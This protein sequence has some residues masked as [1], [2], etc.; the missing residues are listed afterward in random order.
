MYNCGF[1]ASY[2]ARIRFVVVSL[3]FFSS[4]F[5]S[6]LPWSELPWGS[7]PMPPEEAAAEAARIAAEEHEKQA[8]IRLEQEDFQLALE[9]H[10]KE[11]ERRAAD[12]LMRKQLTAED[13]RLAQSLHEKELSRA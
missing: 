13:G 4:E 7:D 1:R 5:R 11:E 8:R 6:Q 10:T 12:E 2:R 9:M 3:R